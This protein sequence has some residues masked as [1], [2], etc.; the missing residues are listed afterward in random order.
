MTVNVRAI[1]PDDLAE[2]MRI[3]AQCYPPPM[4]EP[5]DVILSRSRVERLGFEVVAAPRPELRAALATYPGHACYM[6]RRV[7]G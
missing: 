4:Q 5:E 3:Q 1:R 7:A 2:I 6:S